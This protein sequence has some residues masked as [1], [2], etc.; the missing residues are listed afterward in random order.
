MEPLRPHTQATV[1]ALKTVLSS[2]LQYAQGAVREEDLAKV[3]KAR[4][5]L[6]ASARF[7]RAVR[8]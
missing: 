7:H 4:F 1:H 2:V 5:E 8:R 3:L 6:L